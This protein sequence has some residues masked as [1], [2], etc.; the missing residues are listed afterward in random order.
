MVEI[1][2]FG[3]IMLAKKKKKKKKNER[4]NELTDLTKPKKGSDSQFRYALNLNSVTTI[5]NNCFLRHAS[6]FE[7]KTGI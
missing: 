4:K 6:L 5:K 7:N 3:V 1:C 2:K